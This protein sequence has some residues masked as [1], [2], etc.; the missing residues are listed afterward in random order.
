MTFANGT[1]VGALCGTFVGGVWYSLEATATT[2][3]GNTLVN[4]ARVY[5][6]GPNDR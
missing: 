5:C 2:S 3:L 4:N 1:L 6:Q